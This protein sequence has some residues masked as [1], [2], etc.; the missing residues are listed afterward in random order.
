MEGE[1]HD[2]QMSLITGCLQLKTNPCRAKVSH[3]NRCP[4]IRGSAEGKF[5]RTFLSDGLVHGHGNVEE[6]LEELVNEV[7]VNQVSLTQL[8]GN[9][10]HPEAVAGHPACAVSLKGH[11]V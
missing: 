10:Q 3:D 6:V 11:T 1:F 8:H 2:W 4:F 9:L 7:T 5:Y